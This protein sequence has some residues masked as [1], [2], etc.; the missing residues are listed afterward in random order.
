MGAAAGVWQTGPG[1]LALNL[2][3]SALWK[4]GVGGIAKMF[5]EP[6]V[7]QMVEK[8]LLHNGLMVPPR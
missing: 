2:I 7:D 4:G 6:T 1:G 3:A 5:A 8:L